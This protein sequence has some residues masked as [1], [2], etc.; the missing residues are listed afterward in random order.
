MLNDDEITQLQ[1]AIDADDKDAVAGFLDRLTA[2]ELT[3]LQFYLNNT[4]F[5][6]ACRRSTPEIVALF[7]ERGT[8]PFEL[9]YSDNNELK[10]AVLNKRFPLEMTK[11]VLDWL[12]RDLVEDMITS[13]WDPEEGEGAESCLS[14]LELARAGKNEELVAL[15]RDALKEDRET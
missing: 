15:L 10:S 9:P 12:P 11:L 7:V 13:D 8:A 3:E 6:Y 5:M 14:A 2:E 1:F 4:A